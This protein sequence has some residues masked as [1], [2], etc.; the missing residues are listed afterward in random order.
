MKRKTFLLPALLLLL[1]ETSA[2]A[3]T[4]TFTN[5]FGGNVD[6][7]NSSDF[8]RYIK[9]ENDNFKKKKFSIGERAQLDLSSP[10]LDGRIRSDLASVDENDDFSLKLKGYLGFKPV[11]HITLLAGNSFF[12]KFIIPA[13][14]LPANDEYTIHGKLTGPDGAGILF[15]AAGFSFGAATEADEETVFN[16]GALYEVKN[17]FNIGATFQNITDDARSFGIFAGFDAIYAFKVAGG[18]IRNYKGAYLQSTKNALQLSLKWIL[19]ETGFSLYAEGLLGLTNDIGDGSGNRYYD[20]TFPWY[21]AARL[22]YKLD[23]DTTFYLKGTAGYELKSSKA[24]ETLKRFQI[25]PHFNRKTSMGTIR[26]G[27]RFSLTDKKQ[28]TAFSIPVSW[29]YSFKVK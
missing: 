21:T 1:F 10:E 3:Q 4:L 15:Q 6:N 29:Y 17:A 28:L 25:Y 18:Y 22:L 2:F 8:I 5:T 27:V 19:G 24:G 7:L 9:D 20:T 13:S 23:E 26:S 16:F 14:Y 12:S 11:N